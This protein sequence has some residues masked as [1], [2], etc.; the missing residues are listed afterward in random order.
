MYFDQVKNNF[1]YTKV[2]LLTLKKSFGIH[3]VLVNE[4]SLQILHIAGTTMSTLLCL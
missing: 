3:L 4:S 1:Q 2:K